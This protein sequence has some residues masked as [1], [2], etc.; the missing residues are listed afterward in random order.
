MRLAWDLEQNGR[1]EVSFL[2]PR[3]GT[4]LRPEEL[5]V[6][7][8]MYRHS[9]HQEYIIRGDTTWSPWLIISVHMATSHVS[10]ALLR[11]SLAS[12]VIIS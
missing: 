2:P 10:M 8:A 7:L 1:G 9:G 4:N 6:S 5:Q 11:E 12:Q 3:A